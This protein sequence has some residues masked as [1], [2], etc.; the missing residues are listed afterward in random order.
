VQAVAATAANAAEIIQ[1]VSDEE[2]GY[3]LYV[4]ANNS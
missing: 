2:K 4:I 1:R 3:Y